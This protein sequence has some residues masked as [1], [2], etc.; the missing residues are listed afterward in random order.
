M[1][2][3][4]KAR[5]EHRFQRRSWNTWQVQHAVMAH[6]NSHMQAL[7]ESP[8]SGD[9][10]ANTPPVAL[11]PH[12]PGDLEDHQSIIQTS[13]PTAAQARSSTSRQGITV[14]FAG[15]L[16]QPPVAQ[17][18][19]PGKSNPGIT[20]SMT[21][22]RIHP[23]QL[24]SHIPGIRCYTDASI[25]ADAPSQPLRTAGIGIMFVN[26][27]VSPVNVTYIKAIVHKVSSVVMAEAGALAIAARI[28]AS[29]NYTDLSFLTDSSQLAHFISVPDHNHP[30]EWRMKIYTQDYDIYA[31]TI[32][33]HL[34][35]INRV[36]N[37]TADHLTRLAYFVAATVH[38]P[39]Q[40]DCSCGDHSNQCPYFRH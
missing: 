14:S 31:T 29:L 30:P 11:P 21:G 9:R 39:C 3:I 17:Q 10:A 38:Q 12:N 5:N 19:R 13:S 35:K 4:W 25:I 34:Y 15:N 24:H 8:D 37:V 18:Q 20:S 36:D 27:Q 33:A 28:A 22:T 6:F 26:S 40:V 32:R 16:P 2:Y 7:R 23:L 1:W